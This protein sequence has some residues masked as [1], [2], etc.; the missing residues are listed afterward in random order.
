MILRILY[1]LGLLLFAGMESRVAVAQ[2][3]G[4]M[5]SYSRAV[6][7]WTWTFKQVAAFARHPD[8][9]PALAEEQLEKLS[10]IKDLATRFLAD[11]NA[12]LKT[13][14]RVADALGPAPGED[15]EPEPVVLAAKRK[16]N[17]VETAFYHARIVEAALAIARADEL[18]FKILSRRREAQIDTL[19]QRYPSPFLPSTMQVA[20][21]ELLAE[22]RSL[23]YLPFTWWD[24]LT[25][26]QRQDIPLGYF[27]IVIVAAG[28]LGWA[29]RNFLLRN[30]GRDLNLANPGYGRRLLAAI[31]EGLARGIIPALVLAGIM[32]HVS[33][34]GAMIRSEIVDVIVALCMGLIV[35]ILAVVLPRSVLAPSSPDWRLSPV[36]A[37][38]GHAIC[39]RIIW[40]A[41]IFS[42]DLFA[43]I[44]GNTG[45]SSPELVSLYTMVSNSLGGAGLLLL[46]RGVLWQQQGPEEGESGSVPP[47]SD[48]D[49]PWYSFWPSLRVLIALTSVI[50]I[51][52]AAV[53]YS[54]L[55]HY[56]IKNLI[57]SGLIIGG[58][59]L[60]RGLL[61]EVIGYATRAHWATVTL[62]LAHR[63]RLRIK[64]WARL[65]VEILLVVFGIAT[66]VP[67]WGVPFHEL[68]LWLA[69][70]L[71]GFN[72]GSIRI[73][74]VDIA[75]GIGV[76][77]IGLSAT[78]MLQR[79]LNEQ[80]LPN[81]QL[82]TGVQD[83]LSS[84]FGYVG[85]VIAGALAVSVAGF[86]LSNIALIAGALSVGIGFG[87]Q[88][89]VNN[90]VSGIILLIE[91]PV[92]VGDW[93][94][95]GGNEGL[96]RRINVRATEIQTFQR[97]SVIIPNAD[98][99][100]SAVTNWT[101]KDRQGRV[102]ITVGVAYGSDTALVEKILL[103]CAAEHQSVQDYPAPFVLFQDFGASSLDFD[104][105]CYTADVN[106]R[107]RIASNLRFAI[108]QRFREEG[109]VIPFPQ[110]V[111]HLPDN[112]ADMAP[113]GDTASDRDT[114]KQ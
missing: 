90:F 96:I 75:I 111:V 53:G 33:S 51:A 109:I 56:L 39:R 107:I 72:V 95:I 92:K 88:N 5:P 2:A 13:L 41:C 10:E 99:L 114:D 12:R 101:H 16:K 14:K 26:G 93:V 74:I 97:A 77:L 82:D 7:D 78:R 31:A 55:S 112:A 37:A 68:L 18:E 48:I 20:I 71:Q 80:V 60:S 85:L 38:Q 21:P 86:D 1:F 30:F 44:A 32:W 106:S 19:F 100:S 58:L 98:I 63:T 49:K 108:D 104:L 65:A 76:F 83:S 29:G 110:R 70:I 105:R 62:G 28:F 6:K 42:F 17:S 64:F 8:M 69:K 87:L 113:N 73:S 52:A 57:I 9:D 40:L 66:I 54:L 24:D 4:P 91:R 67:Q 23:G 3:S 22:F 45:A 103:E 89:V 27:F 59:F 61:R 79:T 11:G 25:P 47:A 34:P 36:G 46:T 50:G 84:G 102:E 43:R 81:T 15:A 94:V 35:V